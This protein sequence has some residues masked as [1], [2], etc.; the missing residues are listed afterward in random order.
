MDVKTLDFSDGWPD[1][2]PRGA[3]QEALVYVHHLRNILDEAL[4]ANA[5]ILF[6]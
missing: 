1:V 6:D 3:V 4:A 2:D 5:C